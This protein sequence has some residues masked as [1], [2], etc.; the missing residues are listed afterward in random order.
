MQKINM[1]YML[2]DSRRAARLQ[3]IICLQ[4]RHDYSSNNHLN[5]AS[6]GTS[7]MPIFEYR[8]NS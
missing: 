2:A 8:K 4:L 3:L 5:Q 1:A 7:F 6:K